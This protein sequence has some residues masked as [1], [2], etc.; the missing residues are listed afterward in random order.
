MLAAAI[1]VRLFVCLFAPRDCLFVCSSCG[2]LGRSGGRALH[3]LMKPLPYLSWQNTCRSD[4][5]AAACCVATHRCPD[6]ATH[7]SPT[8]QR[9]AAPTLRRLQWRIRTGGS[10]G[11]SAAKGFGPVR[12]WTTPGFT[13]RSRGQP[14]CASVLATKRAFTGP[15]MMRP[16]QA[17]PR[18]RQKERN[19]VCAGVGVGVGVGLRAGA[20]VRRGGCLGLGESSIDCVIEG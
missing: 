4:A 1:L 3:F 7:K 2:V 18:W 9:T 6:V 14:S 16:S 11:G 12:V 8:L 19:G 20:W 13:V 5:S 10:A 17:Q 15:T